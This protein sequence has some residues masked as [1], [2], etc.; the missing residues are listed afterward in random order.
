LAEMV[1]RGISVLRKPYSPGALCREVREAL[2][3]AAASK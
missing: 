2:D 3:L 1:A